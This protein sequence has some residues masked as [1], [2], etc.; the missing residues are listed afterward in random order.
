MEIVEQDEMFTNEDEYEA[1]YAGNEPFID[2]TNIPS[3]IIGRS[4]DPMDPDTDN[5]G[6]IDGIEVFGWEIL[7]V[8]R[9]VKLLELFLTQDLLTQMKMVFQISWNI[10]KYAAQAQMH[11]ILIQMVMV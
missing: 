10:P 8:N 2:G 7:V 9:G 1:K 6:L 11:L 4:T 5:D 3:E